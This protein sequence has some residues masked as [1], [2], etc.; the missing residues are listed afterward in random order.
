MMK[1]NIPKQTCPNCGAIV[2]DEDGYLIC[3]NCN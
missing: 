2:V 3:K 1:S